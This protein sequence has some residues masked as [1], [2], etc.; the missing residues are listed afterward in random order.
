MLDKC[1]YIFFKRCI[2]LFERE[3]ENSQELGEGQRGREKQTTHAGSPRILLQGLIP[4]P[5]TRT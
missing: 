3:S 2:Y 1:E 4:G 5:G